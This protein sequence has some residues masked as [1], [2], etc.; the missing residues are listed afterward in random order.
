[1]WRRR[2][3][4]RRRRERRRRF[5]RLYVLER[6]GRALARARHLDAPREV[7][8]VAASD[9]HL[10]AARREV[11]ERGDRAPLHAAD[12]DDPRRGLGPVDDRERLL[13]R[14]E[15]LARVRGV[16]RVEI[17][18]PER[19]RERVGRE[20]GLERRLPRARGV[21]DRGAA[22]EALVR[23]GERERGGAVLLALVG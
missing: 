3:R 18:L 6:E 9:V 13:E 1:L 11:H 4:R 19:A 5:R 20:I 7:A 22:R 14:R 12:R 17:A 10:V 8:A 23:L 21:V 15:V 2:R 16:V